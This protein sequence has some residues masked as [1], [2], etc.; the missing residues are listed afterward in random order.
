MKKQK[1]TEH[2]HHRIPNGGIYRKLPVA[3]AND[4]DVAAHHQQ[5]KLCITATSLSPQLCADG[6]ITSDPP[7]LAM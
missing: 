2:F 4:T 7:S 1:G 3:T 6:M 5:I